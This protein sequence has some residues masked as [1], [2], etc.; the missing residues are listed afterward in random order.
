MDTQI[1]LKEY[2]TPA[3]LQKWHDLTG[4]AQH[5]VIVGHSGPDGDALGSA[6]GLAHHFIQQGKEV[7]VLMPTAYPDFLSW[8]PLANHIVIAHNHPERAQTLVTQADLLIC[9]DMNSLLR[10]EELEP[11]LEQASAPRIHIDHH[12]APSLPAEIVVSD[13]TASSTC[14][15]VYCLLRQL[16]ET[17]NMTKETATCIYCG[18][19]TDT[20]AF[21][22]NSNRASLFLIVAELLQKGID[23]DKIY[24]KVYYTFSEGRVRL[25]GY[26]LHEKMRYYPQYHASV[27]AISREEMNHFQYN[28]GDMEGIVNMP[29]EIRG[30]KL[31]ISLREDD[32]KQMIRVSLRSVDNFPC[33]KMAAEFFNGGGHLNASGGHLYCTLQEAIEVAEKALEAYK[34]L[35]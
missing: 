8:L 18:M 27:F 23:K 28:R 30:T 31:S 32:E 22:Y 21:S 11:V 6:L 15:L 29:L 34:N 17:S 16:G 13:S 14:E 10:T 7:N 24:R 12:L 26:I 2:L 5:I 4:R 25:V 1:V 35:L 20:G 19:M 33:N 3:M 9:V